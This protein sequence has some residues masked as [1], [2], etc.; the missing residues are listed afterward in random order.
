MVLN[1]KKNKICQKKN[2]MPDSLGSDRM[3]SPQVEGH[4]LRNGLEKV[5]RASEMKVTS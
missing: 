2:E 4:A 5:C 1:T 3:V